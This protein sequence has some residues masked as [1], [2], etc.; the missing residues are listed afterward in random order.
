MINI[1]QHAVKKD[2]SQVRQMLGRDC[3]NHFT[4]DIWILNMLLTAELF[5]SGGRTLSIQTLY[6]TLSGSVIVLSGYHYQ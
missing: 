3:Q 5:Y 4:T 2:V 6:S 1:E